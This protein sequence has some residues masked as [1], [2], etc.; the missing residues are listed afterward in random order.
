MERVAARLTE[1]ARPV[2]VLVNN[3]GFSIQ[4]RLLDADVSGQDR[5]FEVMMR[6]V[7]VLSGAAGRSMQDRGSGTIINVSS[8]AGYITIG[9]YSAVKAWVTS[10]T[11]GLSNELHGTGVRVLA[12]CPGW[13]RTEFHERGGVR[14]SSIPSAMW[15]DADT[16]VAAAFRDLALRRVISVPTFRYK[17]LTFL[18]RHGPKSAI[19]AV[20]RAISSSRRSNLDT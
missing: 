18:L 5:A 1:T 20:S 2:E 10:Y 14:T 17:A 16:V 15:L 4:G 13:V 12:L 3:A 11:E 8:I 19:R 9:A 7:L 6:A